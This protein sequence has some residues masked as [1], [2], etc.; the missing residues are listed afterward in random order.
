MRSIHRFSLPFLAAAILPL[1]ALGADVEPRAARPVTTPRTIEWQGT[2]DSAVTL[3]SVQRPDG[4]VSVETF[5]AGRNPM[6]R[7]EGLADGVYSYELRASQTD[8]G[9]LVQSGSFT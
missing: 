4:E 5:A 7:L 2:A 8:A 9:P 6:L 1:I 3:L